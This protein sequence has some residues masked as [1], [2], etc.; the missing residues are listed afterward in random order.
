VLF[1]T[2]GK[3]DLIHIP[4]VPT[5]RATTTEVIGIGLTKFDTPLPDRFICYD[6]A[7]LGQKLFDRTEN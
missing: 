6:D 7:S 5:T 4:L 2:N 1:F 3:H